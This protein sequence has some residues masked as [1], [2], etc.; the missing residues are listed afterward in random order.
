VNCLKNNFKIYIKI[1][2]KTAFGAVPPSLGSALFVLA[3]DTVVK[4]A[5]YT[6][7]FLINNML[8][9]STFL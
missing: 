8:N 3:K 5:N 1:D 9:T 4:I 7:L 2:I 6:K